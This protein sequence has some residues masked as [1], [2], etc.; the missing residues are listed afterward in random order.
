MQDPVHLGA[1]RVFAELLS[2]M[3]SMEGGAP[4]DYV[5]GGASIYAAEAA[6]SPFW[7]ET[8]ERQR[9]SMVLALLRSVCRDASSTKGR[10]GPG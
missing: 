9:S 8:H 3:F 2:D 7:N 5:A 6:Q 10:A 1:V 4:A